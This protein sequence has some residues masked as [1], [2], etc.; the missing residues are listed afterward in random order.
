MN[1]L[2][3]TPFDGLPVIVPI[4]D[5]LQARLYAVQGHEA[6]DLADPA[7]A[8]KLYT[9]AIELDPLNAEYPV[10]MAEACKWRK[11]HM[12]TLELPNT[13]IS[14]SDM[15]A[16][17]EELKGKKMVKIDLGSNSITDQ[18]C[19]LLCEALAQSAASSLKSF[20]I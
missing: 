12:P 20:K 17:V 5:F 4:L 3:L 14:D 10:R 6:L 2:F 1:H 13:R 7:L 15:Y 11:A 19:S 18:G 16:I 8:T 9:L